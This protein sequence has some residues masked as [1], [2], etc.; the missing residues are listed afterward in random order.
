MSGWRDKVAGIVETEEDENLALHELAMDDLSAHSSPVL[1]VVH[2]GDASGEPGI[3]ASLEGMQATLRLRAP[4]CRLVILHRF[5]SCYMDPDHAY[6]VAER[7]SCCDWFEAVS[8]ICESP[9]TTQFY[10]DILEDFCD[11]IAPGLGTASDVLVTGLWGD[12][13]DGCAAIVARR[14]AECGLRVR[15]DPASPKAWERGEPEGPGP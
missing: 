13:E 1:I 2:P 8:E 9:E 12:A 10:G 7:R 15:L 6:A 14:L 3:D 11:R 5:S 4:D